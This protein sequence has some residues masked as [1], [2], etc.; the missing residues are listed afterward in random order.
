MSRAFWT[1]AALVCSVPRSWSNE[2]F[3]AGHLLA[4]NQLFIE[5]LLEAVQVGLRVFQLRLVLRLRP[6]HLRELALVGPRV[7]FRQDLARLDPL[8]FG[9]RHLDQFAVEAGADRPPYS[10]A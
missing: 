5:Q 4:R 9:E 7:D 8:S 6:L 3:L 2:R 10:A 1:C